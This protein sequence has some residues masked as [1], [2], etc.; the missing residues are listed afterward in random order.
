MLTKQDEDRVEEIVLSLLRKQGLNGS[1]LNKCV[2]IVKR[3]EQEYFDA[4]NN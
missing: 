1:T 2:A 4:L 3:L